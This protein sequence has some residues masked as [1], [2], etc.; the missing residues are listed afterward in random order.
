MEAGAS[1]QRLDLRRAARRAVAGSLS[2][3]WMGLMPGLGARLGAQTN[4]FPTFEV[5]SARQ[6]L[7]T[8][9]QGLEAQAG[10]N[11]E[12]WFIRARLQSQLGHKDQAER[13]ARQGL[14]RAPERADV[15]VFLADLLIRQDRLEEAARCLR[16]AV[17]LNPQIQGGYRRLGMVLDRLGDHRGACEAFGTAIRL[18][19]AD[20]TARLLLGRW[21]LDNGQVKEAVVE[22]EKACQLDPQMASAFYALAQAQTQLG[23][24]EAARKT[25]QAF[26]E[27]KQKEKAALDA[28]NAAHDNDREMRALAAAFH[29]EAAALFGRQGQESLAEAHLRQAIGIAPQE[30][31][32]YELLASFYLG[33]S[34]WL[35][36]RG[37]FEE[38]ARL[39]PKQL[40][41]RVTL[42]T[43][44]LRLGDYLAAEKQFKGVLE[45]DPKQPE[46]LHNL[47][48]HYLATGR[49]A[50]EALVLCR[51]LVTLQPKAASYDLLGWAFYANGRTNEALAAAAQAVEMDPTNPAYRERYRRLGQ[52]AGKSH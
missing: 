36:A 5:Q 4:A 43:L 30:P 39:R 50:P 52:V 48:R 8:V 15:H 42:G 6:Y 49:E 12:A 11:V 35:E 44:H 51:R 47:A 14:E 37:L 3:L 33:K 27:L 34:R 16:Q 23:G 20:A 18:L 9:A 40:T 17:Q 38:L 31:Q 2:V 26:Q 24:Q 13:L 19:P 25:W 41:Y 45:A 21:L 32:P 28:E 29:S 7:E 46:A 10:T 1:Q 22:L